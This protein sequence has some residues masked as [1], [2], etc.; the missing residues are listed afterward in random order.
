[1][2]GF[3]FCCEV[4]MVHRSSSMSQSHLL[5]QSNSSKDMQGLTTGGT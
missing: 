3:Y 2:C 1:M 5:C 4:M